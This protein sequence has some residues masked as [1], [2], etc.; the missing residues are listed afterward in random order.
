VRKRRFLVIWIEKKIGAKK[1]ENRCLL[2][3]KDLLK[4]GGLRKRKGKVL[5]LEGFDVIVLE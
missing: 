1:G 5:F 4:M 3:F 2:F